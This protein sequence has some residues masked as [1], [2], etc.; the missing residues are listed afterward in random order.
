MRKQQRRWEDLLQR[1]SELPPSFKEA[2]E[3]HVGKDGGRQS[4][5][6]HLLDKK[7]VSPRQTTAEEHELSPKLASSLLENTDISER[8]S[9]DSE[10]E[11][12][13]TVNHKRQS[14]SR[15]KLSMD[16]EDYDAITLCASDGKVREAIGYQK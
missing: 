13:R 1:R 6:A 8:E 16:S 10:A 12:S 4:G 15:S 11:K 5:K 3:G 2:E 14:R 7:V 9:D